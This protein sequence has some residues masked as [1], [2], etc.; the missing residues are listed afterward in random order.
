MEDPR[1]IKGGLA[2]DD[3]G[4]LT[5]ANDF[6][7]DGVKRFYM[8]ENFERG[9]IRAWHGHQREAKYV[10]VPQGSIVLGVVPLTEALVG[11]T[12]HTTDE[13]QQYVLSAKKPEILYIPP[14]YFNGFQT[15][16]DNTKIMF[17][18]TSTLEESMQDDHRLP[19]DTWSIWNRR[20][21]R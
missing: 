13:V 19:W 4:M 18:S 3:R 14:G 15:L 21:Y 2:V 17:F 10:F 12:H 20:D 16:E 5:F 9:F 6:E 8:V 11:A 7:F 1:T